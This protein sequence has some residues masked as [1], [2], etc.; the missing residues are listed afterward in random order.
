MRKCFATILFALAGLMFCSCDNQH[1]Y[2]DWDELGAP[3]QTVSVPATSGTVEIQI[4]A[5]KP[6]TASFDA[7]VDWAL[8]QNPDFEGDQKIVVGYTAN[9]TGAQRSAVMTLKTA[10]RTETITIIQAK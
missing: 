8:I 10:T 5:N 9:T 7:D 3:E 4:Y 2:T 6:G 1:L